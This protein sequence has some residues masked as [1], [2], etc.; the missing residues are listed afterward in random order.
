MSI[1]DIVAYGLRHACR[2]SRMREGS[3]PM[4][5]CL[6]LGHA[7][8]DPNICDCSRTSRKSPAPSLGIISSNHQRAQAWVKAS[9][10]VST[11]H[12]NSASIVVK[13]DGLTTTTANAPS[14]P[15][16]KHP[17]SRAHRTAK[18][19]S[20][21]R[22]ALRPN[23]PTRLFESVSVFNSSRTGRSMSPLPS[24][25]ISRSCWLRSFSRPHLAE[26]HIDWVG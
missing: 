2:D 7:S 26:W 15:P 5:A 1:A 16:G 3:H 18:A 4:H 23:N 21:K 22:L 17:R 12:A 19:S 6:G 9:P 10:R 20:W 24:I 11:Q 8:R 13:T 14:A 25:G